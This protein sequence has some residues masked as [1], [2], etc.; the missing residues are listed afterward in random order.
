MDNAH[1]NCLPPVCAQHGHSKPPSPICLSSPFPTLPE[2][3]PLGAWASVPHLMPSKQDLC[4][5]DWVPCPVQ[6]GT[7]SSAD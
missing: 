3:H 5:P 2:S 6:E 1:L 7:H 4:S